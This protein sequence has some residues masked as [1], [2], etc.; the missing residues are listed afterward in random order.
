VNYLQYVL[1]TAAAAICGLLAFGLT[2]SLQLMWGLCA[3]VVAFVAVVVASN[4]LLRPDDRDPTI[5]PTNVPKKR[6]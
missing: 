6:D 1:A 5:R 4:V 3:A 2:P